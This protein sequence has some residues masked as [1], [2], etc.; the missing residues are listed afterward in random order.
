MYC[1]FPVG[2]CFLRGHG[3]DYF[4]GISKDE[5]IVGNPHFPSDKGACADNAAAANHCAAQNNA[6][7]SDDGVVPDGAPMDDGVM[8]D[9]HAASNMDG[10][11]CVCVDGGIVLHIAVVA[12]C[13]GIGVPAHDGIVPDS[14]IFPCPDIAD[15]VRSR[16]G[17][18]VL[19]HDI[20]LLVCGMAGVIRT[21]DFICRGIC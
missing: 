20:I 7:H 10:K 9:C 1:I 4:C 11:V 12:D 16:G 18:P 17:K 14:Y 13:D 21:A 6:A 5:G 8:P 2:I 19:T 15:D 3:S